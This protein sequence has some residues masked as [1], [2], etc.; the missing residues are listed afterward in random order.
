MSRAAVLLLLAAGCAA[1]SHP[2]T[3]PQDFSQPIDLAGAD[4]AAPPD[5]SRVTDGPSGD[6]PQG[7]LAMGGCGVAKVVINEVQTGG[8]GGNTDEWVELYNACPNVVNLAGS[9]LA[10]RSA[11]NSTPNDTNTLTPLNLTIAAGGYLLIANSGYTGSATPDIKPFAAGGLADTGGAVGLRDSV[12]TLIDSMGWGTASN[13]FVETATCLNGAHGQS[14]ARTPN[15]TDT[16]NNMNDFKI[17][18]TPTPR[19]TN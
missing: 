10:Y 1:P 16:N 7:D 2:I 13:P 19:A 3:P 5:L 4:D 6:L 14:M 11:T 18:T 9:K 17:A 12:G 15:G 8:S